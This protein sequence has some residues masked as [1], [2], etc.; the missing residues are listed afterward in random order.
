MKATLKPPTIC[1]ITKR[2]NPTH[3][4]HSL[5]ERTKSAL[6]SCCSAERSASFWVRRP[7]LERTAETMP[8]EN[9]FVWQ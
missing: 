7:V 3:H 9:L 8:I 2:R 6:P 5:Y 4:R 1:P